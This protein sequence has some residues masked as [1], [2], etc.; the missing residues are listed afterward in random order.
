MKPWYTS[1]TLWVNAL[2]FIAAVLSLVISEPTFAVYSQ[3]SVM[4]LALVNIM[5]RVIT[6]DKLQ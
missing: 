6:T 1:K 3:Y 4:A 2:S 5:L